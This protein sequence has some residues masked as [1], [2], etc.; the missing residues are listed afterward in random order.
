MLG[1]PKPDHTAIK[2]VEVPPGPPVMAPLVAEVYGPDAASRL[3]AARAIRGVMQAQPGIVDVE[4]LP[5]DE[6]E[7]GE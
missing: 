5:G 4:P 3:A 2:V 6:S 7:D 1:L